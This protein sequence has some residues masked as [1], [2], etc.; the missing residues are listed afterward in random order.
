VDTST[1]QVL[2][3]EDQ[4]DSIQVVSQIL[5]FYGIQVHIARDGQECL[6]MLATLAPTLIITD[7][8]MPGLDGWQVLAAVRRN[9]ATAH[10]PVVAVTAYHSVNV[11]QDARRAG[12]NAYFPKPIEAASFV[13]E[14]E[15]IVGS[16]QSD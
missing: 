12:F 10:I 6:E 15:R 7:L 1:W 11:A 14:L 4:E 2:V 13:Q 16:G 8:A 5:E 3:A 9:P